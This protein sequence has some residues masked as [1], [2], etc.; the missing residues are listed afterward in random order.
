MP[1]RSL[2]NGQ[3]RPSILG[4]AHSDVGTTRP[5]RWTTLVTR[6]RP[7]SRCI[8]FRLAWLVAVN[9]LTEYYLQPTEQ[10]PC[11]TSACGTSQGGIFIPYVVT[12]VLSNTNRSD[13]ATSDR[14]SAWVQGCN[15]CER[16]PSGT[17][18]PAWAYLN[19]A[20]SETSAGST[21]VLRRTTRHWVSAI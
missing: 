19:V 8:S 12:A 11:T 1:C 14:W 15:E 6:A 13:Q 7:C 17:A 2:H 4:Y 5:Y 18:V 3:M 10:T 9:G 20:I 16:I 21:F